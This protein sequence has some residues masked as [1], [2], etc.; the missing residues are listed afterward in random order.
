V[1]WIGALVVGII[2]VIAFV[3][4]TL[5]EVIFG[6]LR[7]LPRA[8]ATPTPTP[9]PSA[10]GIF[11]RLR[12]QAPGGALADTT[13]FAVIGLVVLL[14]LALIA[15]RAVLGSAQRRR[16]SLGAGERESLFNWSALLGS[17]QRRRSAPVPEPDSLLD[18][19]GNPAYRHTVRVRR[20]YRRALARAATQDV[21]R[22]PAQTADEVLPALQGAFPVA[23]DPL[24][25]LT[26]LYDATRYTATPAT[27]ADAD[28]A[29]AAERALDTPER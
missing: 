20:A 15:A 24:R 7:D 26:A 27:A 12:E 4:G 8:P 22:S 21:T 25:D 29:E 10:V 28:A 19:A 5:L 9:A 2:A 6:F 18:L 23:R 14:I 13:L 11:D 1:Q 3:I 16:H 17:L